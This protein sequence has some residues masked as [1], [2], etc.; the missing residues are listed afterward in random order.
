MRLTSILL[1]LLFTSFLVTPAIITISG[2]QSDVSTF[3]S[4]NEEENSNKM[5]KP[6]FVFVIEKIQSNY[7][8]LEFLKKQKDKDSFQIDNYSKVFIDV[9][10]PPPRVA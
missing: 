3:F 1:L 5:P 6:N 4:M 7:E 10:S 9:V 2:N 8:S